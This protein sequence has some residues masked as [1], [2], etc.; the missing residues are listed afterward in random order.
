MNLLITSLVLLLLSEVIRADTIKRW[1]SINVQ[2]SQ[3]TVSFSSFLLFVQNV[4]HFSH[5]ALPPFTT[6]CRSQVCQAEEKEIDRTQG[7]NEIV[8]KGCTQPQGGEWTW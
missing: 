5:T 1:N 3:D 4:N 6:W 8:R 2:G 7:Q